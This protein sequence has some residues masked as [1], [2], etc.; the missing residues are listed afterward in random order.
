MHS[1]ILLFVLIQSALAQDQWRL[2]HRDGSVE[3]VWGAPQLSAEQRSE[4][5]AAWVWSGERAPR[6]VE[7]GTIGKEKL[8][9]DSARL[10]I[11]VVR[12]IRSRPPADLRVIAGPISMWRELPEG[13]LP[14]WPVPANG[15]L[16]LPYDSRERWRL[17]VAGHGEGTWWTDVQSGRSP[18]TLSAGSAD[19]VRIEVIGPD[20]AAISPV[21]ADILEG[22]PRAG[23][24]RAWASARSEAGP[25][26]IPGLPDREAVRLSV[27]SAAYAPAV[28]QGRPPDLPR[29]LRLSAGGTLS[30]RVADAKGKL[31]QGAT[32][33]VETWSSPR[34]MQ[35]VLLQDRSREDGSW[36]VAGIPPGPAI[37]QIQAPG[38]APLHEPIEVAPGAVD[39][40]LRHL[41]PGVRLSVLV[42]DDE[43]NPVPGAEVRTGSGVSTTSDSKGMA[44]FSGLPAAPAEIRG[45][46]RRHLEGKGR[47]NP[48]FTAPA[49]LELR[50]ATTL[51]GRLVD[52]AGTPILDGTVQV[53]QPNCFAE[54]R[55]DGEGRFE[56]DLPP[57]VPLELVLRSST[58]V[59]IRRHEEAGQAGEVRD[60]GDLAA[61]SGLTVSGRI[62]GPHG[63]PVP[64]ARVWL[65][66]AGTDGPVLAWARRD[67][68]QAVTDAEGKF[69]LTGLSP[70]P[71]LLRVD[72]AGF[73]RAHVDVA[74]PAE[75]PGIEAGDIR[76]SEGGTIRLLAAGAPEGA[77]ARADLRN[78][79]L[80]LDFVT[81]E[82]REG[83]ATFRHL[84]PGRMTVSVLAD[85]SL[86]CEREIDLAEG[87]DQE[88]EC[89]RD[90]MAVHGTVRVGGVPAGP[91]ILS[92]RPPDTPGPGRID[93]H[94]SPGGLRQQQVFGVGR[95]QVDVTVAEDGV[96]ATAELGPGFW[97]VVWQPMAG[98]A[99]G[100][101]EVEIPRTERAE[102]LL[103]F[104]GLMLSGVVLGE[105][106]QP[107]AGARV[108]ALETG[109]L[110]FSAQDGSFGLPGPESA[111]QAS[112][113]AEHEGLASPVVEIAL[114]P[115]RE[116]G[117]VRLT[118][119]K[120]S[121]PRIEALVV[122]SDGLP[123]ANAFVFLEEEGRGFRILT[124]GADGRAAAAM[125]P[126]YPG[127][128]RLAASSGSAWFL[129]SWVSWDEARSGLIAALDGSASIEILG[130]EHAGIPRILSAGGWDVAA[131][132]LSLGMP[133][134]LSP[135]APLR[136]DGLPPGPY[137]V[138]I[139]GTGST[140]MARA[141]E[142]AEASF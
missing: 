141:G 133:P 62:V 134:A 17:R 95:P 92:W 115:G 89:R 108:R 50:R 79:W 131:L 18:V 43:E 68:L 4:I 71:T 139:D 34:V 1:A 124:T 29:R 64:G 109:A 9:P 19:D 52:E 110:A 41:E 127:R 25:I 66:R 8:P 69:R 105:D 116:P 70:G 39:L 58:A 83:E 85:R 104:P 14:N 23:G 107:V 118:L 93:N 63:G 128:V 136:I 81:A 78:L 90:S 32:V 37:L 80:D 10:E 61:S 2:V 65:P 82:I 120:R 137:T 7:V 48:P 94:M 91:G 36:S 44:V 112:V 20:G 119:G 123:V 142:T 67:L 113:Q 33:R 27:F 13:A 59:E 30:G 6:K 132:L 88:V 126:P 122:G 28:V 24:Q 73:A 26:E 101:R 121:P 72:A 99:T 38:L 16:A 35:V 15:R 45:S 11:R 117:P 100:E 138:A 42:V 129:G 47:V 40:G 56:L 46:A 130:G 60:L 102:I 98:S 135:G 3:A 96:F 22:E 55:L 111:T 21:I 77:L 87:A 53:N 106:G 57:G 114:E 76:L 74:I 54:H 103:D 125:A 31:L 5:Q 97:K 75:P 49:R 86:L 12:Q 140:V 84:P 51:V